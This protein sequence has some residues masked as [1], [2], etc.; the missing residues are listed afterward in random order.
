MA[1]AR[2]SGLTS[3]NACSPPCV[4]RAR[5]RCGPRPRMGRRWIRPAIR[6]CYQRLPRFWPAMGWLLEPISLLLMRRWSPRPISGCICLI[7]TVICLVLA[8]CVSTKKAAVTDSVSNAVMVEAQDVKPSVELPPTKEIDTTSTSQSIASDPASLKEYRIGEEDELEISV[9]GDSEL[10]KTQ[11]V[12][13]DGKIGFPLLGSVRADG[14]TADELREQIRQGL[15]KY[16]INPQVTVIITRYNS[17]KVVVLGEVK[18]PGLIFLSSDIDLLQGISRAGGGTEESDWQGAML[19]RNRQI[20]PVSFEKLLRYADMTQNIFLENKDI[21]LVP[22]ISAKRA[23]ILG[24]V[25][26]PLVV[27]L[28]PGIT[29]M[30]SISMAGGFARDAQLKNVLLIRGGIGSP[31]ISKINVNEILENYNNKNILLKHGDIVYVPKTLIANVS[32]FFDHIRTIIT[33]VVLAETG[34]ALYPALEAV[35]KGKTSG[36]QPSVTLGR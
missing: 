33:P 12:Q 2:I 11:R 22:N 13:P 24:E 35:F 31:E 7:T 34:V 23:F 14:L 4:W 29:L 5:G 10:V 28:R 30:E 17:R 27:A 25:N 26:R 19:I 9:Y 3:S 1:I 32:Q 18:S 36:V 21:I 8:S 15:S 16:L 20:L 6:R